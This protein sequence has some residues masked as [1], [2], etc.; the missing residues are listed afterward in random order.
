MLPFEISLKIKN[1]GRIELSDSY[2]AILA[3]TTRIGTS[4]KA[5]C[6][7]VHE[8]G[9]IPK[10][11]MSQLNTWEEHHNPKRITPEIKALGKEFIARFPIFYEKVYEK[12]FDD[13]MQK[14]VL[15]A[16]GYAWSRPIN[17]EYPRTE[18][19]PNH[20]FM[21]WM[22]KWFCLDNYEEDRN[23]FIKKLAKDYNFMNYAYRI[24]INEADK[25]K[26]WRDW[27]KYYW[28]IIWE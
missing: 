23:D 12:D 11:L 15:H 28:N 2:I 25:K 13:L 14:D 16:A 1:S 7:A 21:I 22:R 19:D 6:Q 10:K 8:F 4:L 20:A 27:I 3:R 24:I 17:G 26:L 18:K 9:V 5:P